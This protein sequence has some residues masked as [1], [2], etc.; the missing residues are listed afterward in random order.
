MTQKPTGPTPILGGQVIGTSFVL[1][2][3]VFL[4]FAFIRYFHVQTTLTKGYFPAS[5]TTVSFASL[6]LFLAMV[7]MLA[8]VTIQR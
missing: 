1:I 8:S 3:M 5:R 2:G 7:V 4:L 6:L